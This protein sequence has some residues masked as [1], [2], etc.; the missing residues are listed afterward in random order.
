MRLFLIIITS[1]HLINCD[2][3]PKFIYAN[4]SLEDNPRCDMGGKL[5]DEWIIRSP[6]WIPICHPRK[7]QFQVTTSNTHEKVW[8]NFSSANALFSDDYGCAQYFSDNNCKHLI[9]NDCL[10]NSI[11]RPSNV[12]IFYEGEKIYYNYACF[13]YYRKVGPCHVE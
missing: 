7:G 11:A 12:I 13:C 4:V 3:N 2:L 5:P 10:G 6:M 9:A 8:L 1:L